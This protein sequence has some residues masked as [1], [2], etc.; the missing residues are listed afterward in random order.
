MSIYIATDENRTAIYG[1][2][3]TEEAAIA[4]AK[5]QDGYGSDELERALHCSGY[6][7]VPCTAALATEVEARGGAIAWDET[8]GV[9][10]V[11]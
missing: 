3:A 9:A 4:D 8:D 11:C 5:D 2:G 10:D 7:A 6:V 1:L